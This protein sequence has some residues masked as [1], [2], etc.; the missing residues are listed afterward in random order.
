M[1]RRLRFA[2]LALPLL[3]AAVAG[4]SWVTTQETFVAPYRFRVYAAARP[5]V[6][7]AF[8]EER[9]RRAPDS[10]LDLASLAA[11]HARA[12]NHDR[13]EELARASLK[14][15]PVFNTGAKLVL[16]QVAQARHRFQES[17]EICRNLPGQES[18]LSLLITAHLA[19]GQVHEA[20]RLADELVDR[21]PGAGSYTQRALVLEATGRE[22][23]AEHDYLKAIDLEEAGEMEASSRTRTYL[24]RFHLRR[25]RADVAKGLLKEAIRIHPENALAHG[26]LA[27]LEEQEPVAVLEYTEAYRL[28]GDAAWLAR[29]AQLQK[30]DALF[31]RALSQMNHGRALGE[32]LLE[33][34]RAGEALEALQKEAGTRRDW[35]TLKALASA[36]S[37]CG[38]NREARAVAREA[39]RTGVRDAE[40]CRLAGV[41]P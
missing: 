15:L 14:L 5:E 7:I 16:A 24:A 30:D 41:R 39:L 17:I 1:S 35:E 26:L 21:W 3:G 12:R 18:A 6:D 27:A 23:E 33:R 11:A 25:G 19:T 37:A 2:I 36:L 9:L 31:D 8:L 29:L 13:A 10:A 32:A 22:R 28:S 20:A 38:R 40:L 34:G 4:L